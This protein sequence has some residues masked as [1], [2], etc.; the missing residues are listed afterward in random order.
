MAWLADEQVTDKEVAK[1]VIEIAYQLIHP[2]MARH[3]CYK[4][5]CE[6]R[7]ANESQPQP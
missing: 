2:A 6:C 7:W 3:L 4:M 1:A 5:R